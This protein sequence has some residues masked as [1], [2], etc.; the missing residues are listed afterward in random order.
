MSFYESKLFRP[1]EPFLDTSA[2]LCA[3]AIVVVFGTIHPTLHTMMAANDGEIGDRIKNIV[4]DT[5]GLFTV[6]NESG[7]TFL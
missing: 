4:I 5:L 1:L 7:T 3:F 6:Q 2:N